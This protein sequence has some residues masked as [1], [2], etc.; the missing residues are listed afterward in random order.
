M[1][2]FFLISLIAGIFMS[3]G[4]GRPAN[5][6]QPVDYADPMIG[7]GGHGHVFL[8]ASVPHG[9]VQLGPVNFVKGWDWCSGYHYSD[10]IVTGFSHTHLSGTGIGDMGDLLVMP[11]TGKLK[12]VPG[13]QEDI[14][15]G[16]AS[17][18]SHAGEKASPGYYS[19]LLER[20][21]ILAEV[22]ASARV[23]FHRYTF[24]AGDTV[25]IL[26]DLERGIGWDA[27]TEASLE[28]VS[29]TLWL[30]YRHSRGWAPDQR[31]YLSLQIS[32]KPDEYRF[33]GPSGADGE[34]ALS[35]K[36]CIGVFTF[37]PGS[38]RTI[39]L[40]AGISPV[41]SANALRNAEAEIPHWDF[42]TTVHQARN[43]WNSELSAI[44][45]NTKNE[46]AARIFYTA[47]YHLKIHPSL[48]NDANGEY[49]GTDKQAYPPPGFDNYSVFSLWDTYRAAHPLF[50]LL[51]PSRVSGFVNSML[52]VFDQQGSLPVWHLQ[53]NE[54]GTMVGNHSIPVIADAWLKGITGFDPDRALEA[55]IKT[56]DSDDG[57]GLPFLKHPG[58]VAAD[59]TRESVSKGLEYGIDDYAIARMASALGREEEC[60][61]F[62]RRA[63]AYRHYFDPDVQFFRGRNYDGSWSE[64]FHPVYTLH[65]QG[66]YTEGNAWQY[67]W[68]VPTDV[69]GLIGLL[70]GEASFT[71]RLDSLFLI[72]P[73][74]NEGASPD[75]SGLIGQYAHGNEPSHHIVYLYAYAGQ[76]WK[77][78]EKVRT[79]LENLY[80]D[81][82]DGICGNEDCG[83]MS[84]W[85]IFSAL[86]F[87]P[88][89][90]VNGPYVLG[91]PLFAE[92]VIKLENGNS[93][94]VKTRRNS[95]RNRYIQT[96]TLNGR[97]HEKSWI[98]HD[99]IVRGGVL[100]ITMGSH[101][102]RK[103]GSLCN[104]RPRS[105]LDL[106]ERDDSRVK[107]L[108]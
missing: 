70:G 22:T 27:L 45:I 88:V 62:S 53:G 85:Y 83:Q 79:I 58:W 68:L 33:F 73:Q 57:D 86:G 64:P 89:N 1:P 81:R 72:S 17:L 76:Q 39:L 35:A 96:V 31:F 66:N 46:A 95:H 49:R 43:S 100:E 7:T 36:P 6:R 12:T 91:S 50:T 102:N 54:T 98:S 80:S 8:G 42:D 29:D 15:E 47:L 28:A 59:S 107:S 16:Y 93:F 103:F 11:Y 61:F 51:N 18:Y 10:S 4:C 44:R 65:E 9:A 13:R 5:L 105:T 84:A 90:P 14:S 104:N 67:L 60:L 21:G 32:E 78:A 87:Y 108:F 55:M 99:E 2:K 82:P 71:R 94:T 77:T 19:V 40:K 24:P 30:G 48:F 75:I 41:S 23:G 63:S 97:K 52:A 25:R 26:V 38:P 56:A 20:Y 3:A 106:P 101:P 92:A 69:E 74:L 34:N 37:Y